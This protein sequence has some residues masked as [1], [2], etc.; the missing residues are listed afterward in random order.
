MI[1]FD[2]VV[3]FVHVNCSHNVKEMI[4]YQIVNVYGGWAMPPMLCVTAPGCS[5]QPGS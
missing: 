5:G 1:A 3:I 2:L 4:V